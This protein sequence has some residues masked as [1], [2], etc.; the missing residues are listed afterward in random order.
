MDETTTPAADTFVVN[1]IET[2]RLY[3][4]MV[5]GKLAGHVLLADTSADG[6]TYH[7]DGVW[8]AGLAD[9]TV[10]GEFDQLDGAVAALI[11]VAL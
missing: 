11:E 7:P 5:D 3:E 10:I 6:L 1:E 4:V 2:D 8:L 9:E